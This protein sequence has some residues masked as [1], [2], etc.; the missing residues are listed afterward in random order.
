MVDEK[1]VRLMTRMAIYE[2][3]HEIEMRPVKRYSRRAFMALHGFG[4]FFIGSMLYAGVVGGFMAVYCVKNLD[5]L[6]LSML[7]NWGAIAVLAYI[8]YI[9]LHVFR[10]RQH[11]K[12]KYEQG[13]KHVKELAKAYK[14][15]AAMYSKKAVRE[16]YERTYDEYEEEY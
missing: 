7:M 3:A 4:A 13:R 2:K 5:S 6:D 11:A 16:E 1:R 8:V 14:Y 9:M 12:K 15:L 10:M